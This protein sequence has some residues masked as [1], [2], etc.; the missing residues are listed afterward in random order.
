[1]P[2]VLLVEDDPF[3]VRALR[4]M[5]IARGVRQITHAATVATALAL[6]VPP[7]DW[8]ILDMNLP[9]GL[10]TTILQ[11]IRRA[12]L[13]IRVIISTSMTNAGTIAAVALYEP[14]LILPKPL[15]PA[16]LPF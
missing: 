4:Q 5:L 15:N 6:L 11:A 12:G 1:M 16:L 9:D 2:H 8:A 14:D 3:T 13:P 7:P 10:G